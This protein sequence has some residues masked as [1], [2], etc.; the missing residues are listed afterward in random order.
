MKR[1]ISF[2]L[3]F[4]MI[5]ATIIN[6]S[7]SYAAMAA[8]EAIENQVDAVCENT[9]DFPAIDLESLLDDGFD[10]CYARGKA[11]S[12]DQELLVSSAEP[13]ELKTINTNQEATAS[14]NQA[15]I[16]QP[17]LRRLNEEVQIDG[18]D[19]TESIF[20][21]F[22]RMNNVDLCYDPDGGKVDLK[23]DYN[24]LPLGYVSEFDYGNNAGYL[25]YIFNEG[26]Y[27]FNFCFVDE[28]G[29]TSS[30]YSFTFEIRRRGSFE[31]ITGQLATE[32]QV[33]TYSID[34]DFSR[35][36]EYYLTLVNIGGDAC[37]VEVK[38]QTGETNTVYTDNPAC[39][40]VV[41][42]G[43][44]ISKPSDAAGDIV[45]YT[46]SVSRKTENTNGD[47]RYQIIYGDK[48][49]KAY[50]T[51]DISNAIDLPYYHSIRN[52]RTAKEPEYMDYSELSD[53]GQYYRIQ[54]TGNERVT[55]VC[56]PQKYHFRIYDADTMVLVA[57]SSQ[58]LDHFIPAEG[59]PINIIAGTYSFPA[60]HCYYVNVYKSPEIAHRGEYSIMVGEPKR[61]YG[62]QEVTISSRY[63]VAGE[64]YVWPFEITPYVGKVAY[65]DT[66][67]YNI[68]GL[69][70][71]GPDWTCYWV[72]T[73]G[74]STWDKATIN[75]LDYHY[76]SD[77]YPLRN[78]VGKWF[79]QI[80][81]SKSGT[82]PENTIRVT[83]Y[84]E[85]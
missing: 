12:I 10:G 27:P 32:S 56:N 3:M 85:V 54:P 65:V 6:T 33:D 49:D 71:K 21:L 43:I 81:P 62:R 78:A 19:T 1:F 4:S 14:T 25:I 63:C 22:T 17:V 70:W 57:D 5:S 64:S 26:S 30:T 38:S 11:A 15:P 44:S 61:Y 51:E 41:K 72:K 34:L 9:T 37:Q 42:R 50:F 47:F 36:E 76:D 28:D 79:F 48:N 13:L 7:A 35:I 18:Q 31:T 66:V 84:F 20:V 52:T 73:P 60:G 67:L 46:L 75:L 55:L 68:P 82:L 53:Y 16:A 83:Y 59:S 80:T 77:S 74:R 24:L 45:T 23:W 8:D 40:Q 69:D 58:Q 2:L 29:A 39:Y